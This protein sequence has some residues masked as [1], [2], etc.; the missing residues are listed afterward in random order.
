MSR[1]AWLRSAQL[2]GLGA[3]GALALPPFHLVFMLLPAITGLIW[4]LDQT[5]DRRRAFR[6]GWTFGLGQGLIGYYCVYSA[7]LVDATAH[8]VPVPSRW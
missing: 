8:G 7:F 4:I 1:S 2:V 5:D 3:I 6:V